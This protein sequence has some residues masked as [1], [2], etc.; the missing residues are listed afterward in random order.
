MVRTPTVL[1]MENTECGAAS[2][3]IVL[4]H[5][6]RYVP[7][8]Q[9]RE[10]CGVSRDGSDAANLILAARSLGLD[11]KGFKKGLD[12]L[13]QVKGPAILFWEF[14]H[15]L[16]F[17]GFRRDRVA[18]NDPALGPRTVS[19]EEFDRSYTGIVLTMEPGPQFQRGGRAP[20]VWPVVVRRMT[21]EPMGAL[22]ILIAG[23]LLILPQL[24][25]PVFAQIYLDEV[26]GN[27]MGQWLKPMLWAMALTIGLQVAL[28]HLQ[29]VGTRSLEKRLTRRF[30]IGF[31][32]QILALPE[33]FYSQR[34][35]SDIAGR[36][37]INASIAEFIGGR[38]IPMLTGLVLLVFYLIL[39]F[40]YS[41]WLGLLIL[42]TT[43]INALVVQLN[44]R[45]QKDNSISL[46][47]DAAKS[48]SV[49]VSAM[50]DIETI[51]AAAI[52][53]DVFRRFAGYQ[54][55]LL[56][57]LQALQLR[58][59]RLRLVPNGLTTFNEI[60]VLLLGFLL[61]IRGELTLGMLLAAQTIAF[62]L[63]GQIER[64]IGF[65]Q[66][67]PEFEAGVLRLEDVLEQ[68]RD[69]LLDGAEVKNPGSTE[70]ASTMSRL[71]GGIEIQDLQYGFTAI[72]APLIDGLSLVIHPGMRVAVVGGS[73]S[74]KS[75]LAKLLAGL[76]QPTGGTIRFDGR[77]LLDLPRAVVVSSLAMVQQEIQLFGCSVRDNLSLW[78]PAID[79]S[80]LLEACRDAEL[81]EVV[82]GLPEGLDTML[83]EGG[84][85]LSGG[86]R[87]RLELARAL[88]N[89]PSI[90]I[91]DEATSALDTDTE[92]KLIN[93]LSRRGCTQ[94]I[95]AHRLSTIRDADLI[96]VMEQ[97]KVIQQGTHDNLLRDQN[98]A[99][100]GLIREVS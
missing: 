70:T 49:V 71:S 91:M 28:Q 67:L 61:V 27:S 39:T 87:Q 79:D 15:F 11:A 99:Y 34:H 50:R 26:I 42:S 8:T 96:L 75:T 24:V 58:N 13:K 92:Q 62:S 45:T 43:A 19:L 46:Q 1:Q 72:Q 23:L 37:G 88:V 69:P 57:T 5:H 76:H 56:N 100:A 47:K 94:V 89:N 60:A 16:V 86:Q 14:N 12:S 82:R 4:Q 36:M 33:R 95:V 2:L 54:S 40:L 7:L 55:R 77:T 78:N 83:N 81:L 41:P 85:N 48:G 80:S 64:L 18:L 22:F 10:L 97:G 6:G 31:E 90:L 98:G 73:G 21:S 9:L 51:K 29:L 44:L 3:S 66:Q 59:A 35:A 74:G 38:L 20:S 93:N 17:E 63:K 68:P 25:M 84:R 53:H 52:E 30:A 32:H 65:V